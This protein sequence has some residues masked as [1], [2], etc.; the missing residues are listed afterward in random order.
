MKNRETESKNRVYYEPAADTPSHLHFSHDA[1]NFTRAHFHNSMEILFAESGKLRVRVS[2]EEKI[3]SAGEIAVSD[4]YDIHSYESVGESTVF[5]L[6][7]GQSYLR[8]FRA[9]HERTFERFLEPCEGTDRI[10]DFLRRT[11]ESGEPRNELTRQGLVSMTLGLMTQYYPTGRAR[12]TSNE[13]GVRILAY[14]NEHF[15]D[16]VHLEDTA[17][18]FGYTPNYFSVLLYKYTGVAFRDYL[19]RIRLEKAEAMIRNGASVTEAAGACGFN[20]LNTYYRAVRKFGSAK[21]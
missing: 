8:D 14:L 16:D 13:L 17:K 11:Y 15:A 5:V 7:A 19:N 20:S 18:E 3:L 9:T 10:F 6:L 2:G 12:C 1:N 21:S 4:G